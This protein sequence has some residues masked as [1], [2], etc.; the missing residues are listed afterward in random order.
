MKKSS[1]TPLRLVRLESPR[2]RFLER[3]RQVEGDRVISDIEY[4]SIDE[5]RVIATWL[6]SGKMCE[7]RPRRVKRRAPEGCAGIEAFELPGAS[8]SRSRLAEKRARLLALRE[9]YRSPRFAS[10]LTLR[11]RTLKSR[12]LLTQE[13]M[14]FLMSSSHSH[15]S[16]R[17]FVRWNRV[18]LRL[19]ELMRVDRNGRLSWIMSHSPRRVS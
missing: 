8:S 12:L 18:A 7:T 2:A 17:K 15:D 10:I 9:I 13:R 5:L 19:L 1:R 4:A 16:V 6:E 11:E 14:L 3:I